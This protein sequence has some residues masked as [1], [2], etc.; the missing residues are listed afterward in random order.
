MEGKLLKLLLGNP[1]VEV[2][3]QSSGEEKVGIR[4]DDMGMDLDIGVVL[5]GLYQF[6]LGL[7]GPGGVAKQHLIE[8]DP[9]RE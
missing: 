2:L 8:D 4:A 5:H 7:G 1:L 9:Q 6:F 3:L